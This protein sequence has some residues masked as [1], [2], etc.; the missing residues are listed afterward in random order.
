MNFNSNGYLEPGIHDLELSALEEHFV[1]GFPTSTT[2]PRI[3]DGYKRHRS[4][5]ESLS[6]ELEQLLDGSFVSTKND[7]GDI[8]L[9]CF[10]DADAVDQLSPDDKNRLRLLT[11]GSSTK[12]S[13][14]CDA[15]FCPTVPETDPRYPTVRQ[16]RKYWMGEFGYD[17]QDRPK[18]ILRTRIAL[19][20]GGHP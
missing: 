19:G 8:D 11:L 5:L 4:E 17:R 3:I 18:G 15:Y 9:V 16:S 2:R 13:H 10:A 12:G 14:L 6:I 7:P 20:K 1:K